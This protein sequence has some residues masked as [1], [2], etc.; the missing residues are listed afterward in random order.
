MLPLLKASVESA[1][2]QTDTD[3]EL[4]V[5]DDGSSDGTWEWLQRFR[6]HSRVRCIRNETTRGL[7]ACRNLLLAES[8]GEYVSILDADDLFSREKVSLHAN[9]LEG[10][11]SIGMVYGRALVLGEAWQVGGLLPPLGFHPRWDL[12]QDYCAV[13]SATTW[14]KRL[15]EEVGGYDPKWALAEAVDLFFKI[16]DNYS[17]YFSEP[18]CCL[19]RVDSSNAFRNQ[20]RNRH[21]QLSL[22]ILQSTFQRRYPHLRTPIWLEG[23]AVC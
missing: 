22:S 15:L 2:L 4:L 7:T 3:F 23:A 12:I 19:K 17:Q 16:G 6:T 21:R 9:I 5:L 14:R 13:H 20:I 10:D 1:L 11:S 8:R 18:I